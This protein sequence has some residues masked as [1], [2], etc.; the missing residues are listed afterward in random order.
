MV[1]NHN[2]QLLWLCLRFKTLTHEMISKNKSMIKTMHPFCIPFELLL[3]S[4][5]IHEPLQIMSTEHDRINEYK[6]LFSHGLVV[7]LCNTYFSNITQCVYLPKTMPC[8]LT[9]LN[10]ENTL[11]TSL[12]PHC[13]NNGGLTCDIIVILG[14][15][16]SILFLCIVIASLE[17]DTSNKLFLLF[18]SRRSWKSI[19]YRSGSLI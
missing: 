14:I 18:K 8:Y 19:C 2:H 15:T 12:R 3:V 1:I 6:C 9:N 17:P 11:Y 10:K 4:D 7:T 5:L 16:S 13:I